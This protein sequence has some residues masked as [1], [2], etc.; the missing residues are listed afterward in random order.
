MEVYLP[1]PYKQYHANNEDTI[2]EHKREYI[3]FFQSQ[4]SRKLK[5]KKRTYFNFRKNKNSKMIQIS[6]SP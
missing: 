1:M 5:I 4:Q 3:R 2:P 6:Y